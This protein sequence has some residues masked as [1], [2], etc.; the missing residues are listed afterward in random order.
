MDAVGDYCEAFAKTRGWRVE[1]AHLDV[2]GDVRCITMNPESSLAPIAFSG[3]MDTVHEKGSF[4]Y[5]A[6][7]EDEEKLYG[8]GVTD[9]KGGIA[10]LV[11]LRWHSFANGPRRQLIL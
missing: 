10:W 8:P 4:G 5:P 3:H 11:C 9:C 2:P 6:V 7:T 1:R